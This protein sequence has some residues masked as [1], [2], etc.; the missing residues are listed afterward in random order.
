MVEPGVGQGWR[1]AGGT[2]GSD[3][4]SGFNLTRNPSLTQLQC[5]TKAVC[6]TAISSGLRE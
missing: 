4:K 1:Y 6:S 5:K 2:S 3:T